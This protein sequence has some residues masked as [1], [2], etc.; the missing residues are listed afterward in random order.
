MVFS[1]LHSVF[2]AALLACALTGMVSF[3]N[4]TENQIITLEEN[5]KNWPITSV[6]INGVQTEALVDT[7][8]TV[9]LI[10][11]SFLPGGQAIGAALG[12]TNVLGIGGRRVYPVHT[13]E[14]VSAGAHVWRDVRAAITPIQSDLA[15]Y[16]VLP[17][18]MFEGDIL[19]FDFAEQRL[20]TYS[21]KPRRISSTT[22]NRIDYVEQDGLVFI[23]IQINGVRGN[24]LIDTGADITF[25]NRAFA[26]Q[27][28]AQSYLN[29]AKLVEGSDLEKQVAVPHA[30]RDL[31]FGSAQV[32]RFQIP[33]LD[34]ELFDELGYGDTPMMVMGMDMLSRFRMQID[35]KR[36]RITFLSRKIKRED[37]FARPTISRAREVSNP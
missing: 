20:R 9:A 11:Q 29:T 35:R 34:S 23:P 18:S 32:D 33:V 15:P 37:L 26:Q 25:V 31:R 8:A 24:A 21:G 17:A 16:N 7:A 2:R 14:H 30:F 6:A 10:D 4:A 13:L 36:K 12:E 22:R 27:A 5:A 1:V 3:A 19:D 28:R